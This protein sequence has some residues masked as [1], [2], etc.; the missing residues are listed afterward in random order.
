M[1]FHDELKGSYILV[2]QRIIG[3]LR[4]GYQGPT[5]RSIFKDQVNDAN[6]DNEVF[7]LYFRNK[8]DFKYISP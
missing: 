8:G 5:I 3:K 2:R 4:N 6:C 7:Q 1:T